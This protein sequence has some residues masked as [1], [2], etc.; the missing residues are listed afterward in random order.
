MNAIPTG[1]VSSKCIATS[2]GEEFPNL[3]MGSANYT[4]SNISQLGAVSYSH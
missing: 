1:Q 4:P 3:Y 2:A